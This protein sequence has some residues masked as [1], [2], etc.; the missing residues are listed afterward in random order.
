[1]SPPQPP[2]SPYPPQSAGVRARTF[3]SRFLWTTIPLLSGGLLG[4]VPAL[5]VARRRRT[6]KA[7]WWFAGLLQGTVVECVLVVMQPTNSTTGHGDTGNFAGAFSLASIITAT[8]Y[9]WIS[10][11]ALPPLPDPYA[12]YANTMWMPTKP[13]GTPYPAPSPTVTVPPGTP[14]PSFPSAPPVAPVPAPPAPAPAAATAA[15]EMAAEVQ[16]ELRELRGFLGG[17]DAR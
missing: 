16:A 10:C 12:G 11:K 1:M 9:S 15:S 17:E 8:A 2:L 13:E 5:H 3:A 7:W 14:G 4:W 6:P